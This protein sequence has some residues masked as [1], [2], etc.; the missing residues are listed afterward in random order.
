ME[1]AALKDICLTIPEGQ[2]IGLIGHTGSGK[3]TLVQHLNGLIAPTTGSVYYNGAD[4]HDTD[5]NKKE[6]RSRVG[7]VF[8]YRSISYLKSMCFP[9]CVLVRRI[10]DWT[11][12][13]WSFGPMRL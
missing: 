12:R 3:S 2:F 5:Y 9:T 11:R 4:I 8:Q 10:W 6:L 7:L 13:K 1:Y